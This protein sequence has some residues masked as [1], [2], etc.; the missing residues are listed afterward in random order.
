[1]S[2]YSLEEIKKLRRYNGSFYKGIT[3]TRK[4]SEYVDWLI[5]ALEKS[6]AEAKRLEQLIDDWRGT[7]GLETV[8]MKQWKNRAEKAEAE[9]KRLHENK[10]VEMVRRIE[11]CLEIAI[12][13]AEN[14]ED[15]VKRLKERF[16]DG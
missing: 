2:E 13:R 12:D 9:V 14:A 3:V 15:E 10:N 8:F 7:A 1:M 11:N 16:A 5:S 4:A 6:R